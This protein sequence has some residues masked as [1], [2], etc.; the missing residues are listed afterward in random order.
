MSSREELEQDLAFYFSKEEELKL[1]DRRAL[2][3]NIMQKHFIITDSDI[4]FNK[5]DFDRI[6]SDA[7]SLMAKIDLPVRVSGQILDSQ[8]LVS[9]ALIEATIGALNSKGVTKRLVKIDR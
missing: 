9:L 4:T 2:L 5:K 7:K 1:D 8:Q 3:R 6:V